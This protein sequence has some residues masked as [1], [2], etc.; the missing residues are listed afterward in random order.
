MIRTRSIPGDRAGLITGSHALVHVTSNHTMV[1]C[2]APR[3]PERAAGTAAEMAKIP[4]NFRMVIHWIIVGVRT[5][6]EAA[7]SQSKASV[8]AKATAR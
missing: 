5:D 3:E 1:E 2:R 4:K 8:R 6:F 7:A